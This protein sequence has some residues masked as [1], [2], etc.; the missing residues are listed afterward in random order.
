MQSFVTVILVLGVFSMVTPFYLP[1]TASTVSDD[2]EYD[3]YSIFH[4]REAK[5]E[6][7]IPIPRTMKNCNCFP[8]C[9]LRR[10]CVLCL[11]RYSVIA[12][13]FMSKDES[14]YE[15]PSEDELQKPLHK[16]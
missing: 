11:S 6:P 9:C 8:K 13:S 16:N 7:I 14:T 1:T 15:F 3:D 12:R 5:H 2:M 10:K 4:S